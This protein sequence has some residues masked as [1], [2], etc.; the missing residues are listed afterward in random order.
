[1]SKPSGNLPLLHINPIRY[2]RYNMESRLKNIPLFEGASD[3]TLALLEPLFENCV[4]HEG[5]IFEQGD[6]AIHFYLLLEGMVD[7]RYKPYDAPPITMTTVKA[8]GIFGWSAIAGKTVYTSSALCNEKCIALRVRGT[9]LRKLCI[10]HPE[11]GEVL[12]DRIA[13]SV[14]TRWQNAQTQVREI[15]SLGISTTL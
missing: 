4:C 9:D 1:M 3:K 12:L 13:Q 2:Y 15:L 7:L 6:P 5:N 14:S 10:E 11:T 8:G